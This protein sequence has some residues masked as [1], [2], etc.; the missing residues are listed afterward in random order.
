MK[1][2]KN[3]LLLSILFLSTPIFAQVNYDIS[4]III[5]E[6]FDNKQRLIARK[7]RSYGTQ[8]EESLKVEIIVTPKNAV[9][10]LI[11]NEKKV[12]PLMFKEYRIL[13]DYVISYAD[14]ERELE[15]PKA[16]AVVKI[17]GQDLKEK[18]TETEKKMLLDT[19]KIELI[20]DGILRDESEPFDFSMTGNYLFFNG[21]QQDGNIYNKYKQIYDRLC[22]IPLSK[23]TYFQITQTL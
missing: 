22:D 20:N 21:N 13:T 1:I 17:V 23:T 11:V 12:M 7:I 19:L 2:L 5:D 3:V 15:K 4:T 10:E 18:L 8:G 9:K 14:T 6:K 16:N